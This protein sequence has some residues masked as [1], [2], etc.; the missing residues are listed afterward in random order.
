MSIWPVN[1]SKQQS[2]L[3]TRVA[4]ISRMKLRLDQRAGDRG[5]HR[6]GFRAGLTDLGLAP[7]VVEAQPFPD[8]WW[9]LI[10]HPGLVGARTR[11]DR[12]WTGEEVRVLAPFFSTAFNNF[13]CYRDKFHRSENQHRRPTTK[14]QFL[15]IL[16][17]PFRGGLGPGWVHTRRWQ[18]VQ[19][20]RPTILRERY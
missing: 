13:S 15:L 17:G 4:Q 11:T 9:I 6:L 7:S 1:I 20:I 14:A 2:K 12:S 16:I 10:L 19:K 5:P 3:L 8:G 18:N